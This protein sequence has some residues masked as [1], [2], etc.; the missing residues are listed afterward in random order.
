MYFLPT[1]ETT[2]LAKNLKIFLKLEVKRIPLM[3]QESTLK[4][5]TSKESARPSIV[6]QSTTVKG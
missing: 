1:I 3:A 6:Y 4:L 2:Y 5:A